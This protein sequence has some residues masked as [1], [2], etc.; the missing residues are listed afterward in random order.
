[1]AAWDVTEVTNMAEL[2][3]NKRT[4]D[5]DIGDWDVSSVTDMS[6]MFYGA[7]FF[8]RTLTSGTRVKW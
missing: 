6:D 3:K 1:M 4:F 5:V 7:K 2:L 8:N